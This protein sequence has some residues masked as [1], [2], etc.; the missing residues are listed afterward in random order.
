MDFGFSFGFGRLADC[1][2]CCEAPG[3]A[4]ARGPRGFP[5]SEGGEEG[6]LSRGTGA[7]GGGCGRFAVEAVCGLQNGRGRAAGQ[8]LR[9]QLWASA[10]RWCVCV[11][12]RKWGGGYTLTSGRY[13]HD[14]LCPEG[15]ETTTEEEEVEAFAGSS[16]ETGSG[17]NSTRRH[18][19]LA[20]EHPPPIAF[21]VAGGGWSNSADPATE[22]VRAVLLDDKDSAEHVTTILGSAW[23]SSR[24]SFSN[25]SSIL[26]ISS[27]SP[28]A[29][30]RKLQR[31][32]SAS[33]ISWTNIVPSDACSRRRLNRC[34][35]GAAEGSIGTMDA[36]RKSDDE[37]ALLGLSSLLQG[38]EE[39]RLSKWK[40]SSSSLS[41]DGDRRRLR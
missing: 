31:R 25:S 12:W 29:G 7:R 26:T 4:A 41:V 5:V 20:R 11:R 33:Q 14:R 19:S 34:A 32:P 2:C 13:M 40:G 10:R 8:E 17:S 23:P 16:S 3:D 15:L 24:A 35:A 22:F 36:W 27:G 18:F 9:R 30:T 1:G 28:L 6:A 39:S 37:M 21:T 38:E